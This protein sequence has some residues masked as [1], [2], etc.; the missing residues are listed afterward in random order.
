[1]E[2]NTLLGNSQ[3]LKPLNIFISN[4]QAFVLPLNS[5][6]FHLLAFLSLFEFTL[7]FLAFLKLL[8]FFFL[9]LFFSLA[10]LLL[11]EFFALELFDALGALASLICL[12]VTLLSKA[13]LLFLNRFLSKEI[14]LF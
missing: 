10:L 8:L 13:L 7:F 5:L 3:L 9:F 4:L 12:H 2:T 1:M 14:L 11:F 6:F